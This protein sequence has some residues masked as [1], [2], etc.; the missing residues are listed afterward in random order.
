MNPDTKLNAFLT[1][2]RHCAMQMMENATYIQKHLPGLEAPEGTAE[3]IRAVCDSLTATKH[4]VFTELS[5]LAEAAHA[6]GSC[7]N[8]E[9][10]RERIRRWLFEPLAEMDEVVRAL[11]AAAAHDP[12]FSLAFL[13]MSE[14]A[15][16]ILT[17]FNAVPDE[18][19]FEVP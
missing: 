3:R 13:L 16:N 8:L 10:R 9:P 2:A 1:A 6:A 11:E 17:A 19:M 4:D 5:E 7:L 14:S 15:V 12:A 18:G